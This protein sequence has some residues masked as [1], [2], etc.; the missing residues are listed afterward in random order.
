MRI[1]CDTNV[2][3]SG[4]LFGGIPRQ[5]LSMAEDEVVTIATSPDL[6]TEAET[7]LRRPK[8]RL[9]PDQVSEILILFRSA[10]TLVNPSRRVYG[11]QADPTDNAVLEAAEAATA[12]IIVSGDRHLL[13][14]KIWNGIRILSPAAFTAE[15]QG[16]LGLRDCL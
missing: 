6:L 4:F 9:Q 8:F 11:V 15:M 10:S 12:E 16:Q 14:L 3:V 7:V 5:I 13:D 1:V 2:L